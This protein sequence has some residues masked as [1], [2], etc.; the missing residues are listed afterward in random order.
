[1]AQAYALARQAGF[2]PA[3]AVIA[4]AIAAGESGLNPAAVGD[5]TLQDATWGPSVGLM[6]V[7]T[8]KADTGT[9]R[10]RDITVLR[11]PLANMQAAYE[12]S[13]GGRDW[14]PWSVY[15]SGKYRTFLGQARDAAAVAPR[16]IPGATVVPAG[17]SDN[18]LAT[19]RG[20]IVGGLVLAGGVAL[21][22]LGA[23]RAVG[24]E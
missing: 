16:T 12:I 17:L 22:L 3:S 21:V 10:T 13:H 20:L 2:D 4:A 7:R 14:T 19:G 24:S 11:D 9:G 5:V 8:L 1:M 15:T 18:V 23:T 6:Q